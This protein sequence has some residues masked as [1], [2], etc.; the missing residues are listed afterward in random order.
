MDD[1]YIGPDMDLENSMDSNLS[2]GSWR[3]AASKILKEIETDSEDGFPSNGI[4]TSTG[5][6]LDQQAAEG[7]QESLLKI[8]HGQ[9]LASACIA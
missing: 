1:R 7:H 5:G 2:I 6:A 3:H 8:Y 4:I 9:E